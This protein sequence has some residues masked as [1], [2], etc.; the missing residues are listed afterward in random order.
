MN[1]RVRNSTYSYE[2]IQYWKKKLVQSVNYLSNLAGVGPMTFLSDT[3]L[4]N[5][6]PVN[7]TGQNVQWT[8]R[9]EEKQTQSESK[10]VTFVYISDSNSTLSLAILSLWA[11]HFSASTFVFSNNSVFMTTSSCK[12]I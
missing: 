2:W 3:G 4:G 6:M 8:N 7:H 9:D 10:K 1:L 12:C 5:A 11:K